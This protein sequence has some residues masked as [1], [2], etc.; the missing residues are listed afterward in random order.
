MISKGAANHLSSS[1]AAQLQ[2]TGAVGR[3]QNSYVIKKWVML[4]SFCAFH[5]NA[6]IYLL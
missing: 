5:T 2:P 3:R 6:S 4:N 1:P